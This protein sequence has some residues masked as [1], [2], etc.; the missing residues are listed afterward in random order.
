PPPPAPAGPPLPPPGGA[1][2]APPSC[3]S[4]GKKPSSAMSWA[5]VVANTKPG[6]AAAP[7][8]PGPEAEENVTVLAEV[9][10]AALLPGVAEAGGTNTA[11]PRASVPGP[12]RVALSSQRA[13]LT[14][15]SRA[16][17]SSWGKG[18]GGGAASVPAASREL[19]A[20]MG[21]KV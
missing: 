8:E 13:V 2:P 15:P 17:P 18:S 16:E 3:G 19:G 12:P 1:R 10:G 6:P 11:R 9:P 20:K 5:S 21:S 4:R 14:G 7:A